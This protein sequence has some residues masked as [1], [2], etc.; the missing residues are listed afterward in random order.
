MREKG[1]KDWGG[2][3]CRGLVGG[4]SSDRKVVKPNAKKKS[5]TE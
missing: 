5:E 4:A 3:K 1:R 2:G